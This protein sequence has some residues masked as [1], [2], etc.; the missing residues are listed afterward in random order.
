MLTSDV[1]RTAEPFFARYGFSVVARQEPVVLG[2]VLQNAAMKKAL[3]L[4]EIGV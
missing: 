1:S 4:A 2:V 3:H